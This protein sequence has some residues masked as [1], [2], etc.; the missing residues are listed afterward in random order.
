MPSRPCTSLWLRLALAFLLFVA[1][2]SLALVLWLL[3]RVCD[4][5]D[6]P[7]ARLRSSRSGTGSGGTE[8][9]GDTLPESR[10]NYEHYLSTIGPRA[11]A[12]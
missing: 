5:L 7:L 1:A 10:A 9:G 11:R 2:G 6:G 12:D 4:G 8:A 3:S